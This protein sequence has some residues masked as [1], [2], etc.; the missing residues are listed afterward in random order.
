MHLAG[1]QFKKSKRVMALLLSAVM[2]MGGCGKTSQTTEE[3]ALI[4]PVSS[5]NVTET[6]SRRTLYDY[7]VL[8]GGVFPV[9]TEYPAA[10]GMKAADIG[11]FPGQR[12][13]NGNVLFSGDMKDYYEQEKAVRNSLD[14]LIVS[15]AESRRVNEIKLRELGYFIDHRDDDL[16]N[17]AYIQIV[18]Q[19]ALF[20]KEYL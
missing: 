2:L 3:I 5:A 11:Y 8:D 19:K 1:R 10:I 18:V 9:V 12:V 20:E 4:D 15:Y 13:Y 16:E 6:V 17:N 14:E 7:D